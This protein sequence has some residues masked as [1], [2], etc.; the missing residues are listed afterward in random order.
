MATTDNAAVYD[1]KYL[2][3]LKKYVAKPLAKLIDDAYKTGVLETGIFQRDRIFEIACV[4]AS[5]GLY[6]LD[7]V[8]RWDFT[9]HSEAKSTTVW[10]TIKRNKWKKKDGT[11]SFYDKETNSVLITNIKNKAGMIR[12]MTYDPYNDNFRYYVIWDYDSCRN[13][14]R[15]QFDING[16]SKYINGDCGKEVSTFVEMARFRNLTPYV[17]VEEDSSPLLE[18][19]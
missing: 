16:D 11:V 3:E 6:H 10:R 9:D 14:D 19:A 13:Y 8:D 12:A 2:L 7:S 17:H 4:H 18:S 1:V 15:V 5:S